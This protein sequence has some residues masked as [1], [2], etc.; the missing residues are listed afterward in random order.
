M[1]QYLYH[2]T[3]AANL[4]GIRERGLRPDG[5]PGLSV[6]YRFTPDDWVSLTELGPQDDEVGH[7]DLGYWRQLLRSSYPG[8]PVVVLRVRREALAPLPRAMTTGDETSE[9]YRYS[10]VIDPRQIEAME[11]GRWRRL[12]RAQRHRR[13]P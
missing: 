6:A 3:R 12:K 2:V 13:E 8:E 1:R 4:P 5:A 7:R 11:R 9:E 10:G